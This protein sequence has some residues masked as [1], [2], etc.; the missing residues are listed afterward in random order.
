MSHVFRYIAWHYSRALNSL[1]RIGN[2][3]IWFFYHFFSI[4][5]LVH[6][7]FVPW[8]RL[9][10]KK[11]TGLDLG[12]MLGRLIIN[13]IM[14]LVGFIVRLATIS[15]GILFCLGILF[16]SM[17]CTIFWLIAPVVAV[18]SVLVG[19]RLIF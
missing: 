19:I 2:N 15:V 16:V 12:N 6:T 8:R 9:S 5:L 14:R 4:P 1:W 7:M 10:E 17:V 18:L 11:T 13:V 3:L